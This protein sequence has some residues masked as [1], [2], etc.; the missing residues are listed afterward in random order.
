M[1]CKRFLH[2]SQQNNREVIGPDICAVSFPLSKVLEVLFAK[3]LVAGSIWLS[4]TQL[5][6]GEPVVFSAALRKRL[7]NRSYEHFDL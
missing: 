3:R 6:V 4:S 7:P 2:R 1:V 5:V